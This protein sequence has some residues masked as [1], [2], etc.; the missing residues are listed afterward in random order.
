MAKP[1]IKPLA[2]SDHVMRYIAPGRQM[3]DFSTDALVGIFP[4]AFE[5]REV[6]QGALSVTWIEYFG[7][8]SASHCAKAAAQIQKSFKKSKA[9]QVFAIGNVGAIKE[10]G[11]KDKCAVRVSHEP[12][13]NNP[14]HSSIRRFTNENEYLLSLLASEVFTDLRDAN[15]NIAK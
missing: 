10:S 3:R 6:D 12:T 2:N 7:G 1:K 9:S 4:A 5:L 8:R 14:A 13:A 15:G 11:N